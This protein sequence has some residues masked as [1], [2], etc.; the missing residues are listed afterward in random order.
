MTTN[1]GK[2]VGKGKPLFTVVETDVATKEI[3]MEASFKKQT[4]KH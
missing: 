3:G 4:K 2:D 1:V